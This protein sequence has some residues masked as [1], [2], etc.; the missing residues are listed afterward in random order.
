MAQSRMSLA[1]SWAT[2]LLLAFVLVAPFGLGGNRPQ[3]WLINLGALALIAAAFL[4]L[5]APSS[6]R[7]ARPAGRVRALSLL[8]IAYPALILLW[9]LAGWAFGSGAAWATTAFGLARIASYLLFAWLCAQ[10]LRSGR[11]AHVAAR[12]CVAGLSAIA[13]YGMVSA[14]NPEMLLYEKLQYDGFA[15]G[16]FVNRNSFATF[17]AMGATLS[18][19]LA[20]NPVRETR[21]RGRT[22]A[23]PLK[24]DR[25][26]GG[27]LAFAP[28]PLFLSAVLLTGSRMGLFATLVGMVTVAATSGRLK[29][30]SRAT[31]AGLIALAALALLAAFALTFGQATF[32]RLGSTGA[33][34][35][36]RGSLYVNV[37]RMIAD[38]PLLGHGLDSFPRAYQAYHAA[39]VSADL[40]W[41]QAHNTYLELWS[42]LGLIL[43][44]VPMIICLLA[45]G[46]LWARARGEDDRRARLASA[47]VGCLALGAVHSLVDFSLEM[48]ANVYLLIFI[49][50]L[51]LAPRERGAET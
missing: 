49:C 24:L 36:V 14:G 45:L 44:S 43:G 32:E 38:A 50:A 23:N 26:L 10:A 11:R 39:P 1:N 2:W 31:L 51:G 22:Q 30:A 13:A 35:D 19:A 5:S 40:R 21:R 37:L 18:L 47:G 20:L 17:L 25:L 6:G 48:P 41:D 33:S 27:A 15:T 8:A 7:L 16:P 42:E 3:F 28:V 29:S 46:A 34:A 9:S 12:L 4:A